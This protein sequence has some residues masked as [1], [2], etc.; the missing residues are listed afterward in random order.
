[1]TSDSRRIALLILGGSL[2][3]APDLGPPGSLVNSPRILVVRGTPPE[4][5]PGGP[6]DSGIVYDVLA[7]TPQG[8]LPIP[9]AS[10]D[11]CATPR[12]PSTNNVIGPECLDGGV[13]SLGPD[14]PL[15]IA[16]MPQN[17][18]SIFGPDPPPPMMGQPPARPPDPDATGGYYEP[19]LV[20]VPFPGLPDGFYQAAG[21]E[22]IR[23]N[24][25]AGAPLSVS[26]E[27]NQTYTLNDNPVLLGVTAMLDGGTATAL[28]GPGDGGAAVPFVVPPGGTVTLEAS[29]PASSVQSF[30]V[31]DPETRMLITT[32]EILSVAWY[33]TA[34]AM[35]FDLSLRTGDDP[36]TVAQNSWVA[37][38]AGGLVHVWVVLRDDR[39]GV[40]YGEYAF[41]VQ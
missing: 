20:G 33:A 9:A 31:F 23:C 41:S 39:G 29:W 25:G 36:S 7:V 6:A 21:L 13:T 2:A 16:K 8:R 32:K 18:C 28:V 10:W 37:T 5:F 22:R 15:A 34:G 26:Q 11:Y 17:A 35:E 14:G 4:A 19:L 40:D 38:D 24:L 27:Y 30:P 12:P 1:L 3:C